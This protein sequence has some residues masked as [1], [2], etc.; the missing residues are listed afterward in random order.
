[1]GLGQVER[2]EDGQ[3]L[4]HQPLGGAG[5]LL[6]LA[7]RDLL[8]VVLEVGLGALQR[9]QVLVAL[10]CQHVPRAG[11][12]GRPIV[13]ARGPLGTRGPLGLGSRPAG[14]AR[15]AAGRGLLREPAF[16]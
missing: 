2:V 7:P 9:A 11:L 4:V 10:A 16:V 14:R 6:F 5:R 1:M 15:R 12:V 8:A 3:Q 13:V